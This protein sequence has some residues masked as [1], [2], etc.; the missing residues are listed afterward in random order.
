MADTMAAKP[1][2]YWVATAP[3]PQFSSLTTDFS[4]DVVIVGGGI[5]GLTAATFLKRAGHTVAVLEAHR[6][7]TQTTGG[8]TAKITSQHSLIYGYLVDQFGE[9]GARTYAQANQAAIE[10][11]AKFVTDYHIDCDFERRSAYVYTESEDQVAQLRQEA[12][13]AHSLGL[14]ATV[15]E[16]TSLP[17]NVAAALKFENQAQFH[18]CKY[19]AGLAQFI[20][21]DGSRV[22]ENTRVLAVDDA[23]PCQITTEQGITVKGNTV[24]VATGL[25]ILDRGGYFAKAYPRAHL[26]LAARL[27]DDAGFNGMFISIDQ[28]THSLRLASDSQNS[29]LIAVGPSFRTGHDS[30]TQQGY[31]DLEAF[32]RQRFNISSIEHR[33]MNEDFNSADRVPYVG[34]LLPTSSHI[35]VATGFSGWGISNGTAAAEI[36]ADTIRGIANPWATF[37]TSTRIKPITSA[38]SFLQENTQTAKDWIT[39]HLPGKSDRSLNDLTADEGGIVA[40]ENEKLAAYKDSSGKLYLLSPVCS[41]LGCHVTWNNAEKTWDC[42]CH[43]SRFGYDGSVLQGPAV[44]PLTPK[45]V[46]SGQQA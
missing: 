33:W 3:N 16:E 20:D 25:P 37:Y 30:D 42:P 9:E 19:A 22:C 46:D 44:K 6:V 36:L 21:G 13:I 38:K 23:R 32:V 5:V 43:G 2:S 7:G 17:F 15:V 34:K 24:I 40:V 35:Y 12:E 1:G 28:P 14:P 39:D 26:V 11:I 10:Q 45:Q 31:R 8:S 41:H 29:L 4:V 27:E 18:P